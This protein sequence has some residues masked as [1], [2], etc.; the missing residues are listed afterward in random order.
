MSQSRHLLVLM[1]ME[2]T[3]SM[4]KRRGNNAN[5]GTGCETWTKMDRYG[6]R[7]VMLHPVGLRIFIVH[8]CGND[9]PKK[10]KTTILF[11]KKFR[12][13]T[14]LHKTFLSI[15]HNKMQMFSSF[16]QK[17]FL[18]ILF[19]SFYPISIYFLP[20]FRFF[21]IKSGFSAQFWHFG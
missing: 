14:R 21:L 13:F 5:I 8:H 16:L 15:Q 19:I 10:P 4:T 20:V 6:N 7:S 17:L 18:F 2:D 12:I 1:T 9:G 3:L 11:S